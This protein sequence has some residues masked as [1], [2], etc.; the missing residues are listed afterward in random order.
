MTAIPLAAPYP[1]FT[2]PSGAAL[3]GGKIYIG[4]AGLDPRTN[5]ITVYQDA[6]NT[7]TWAQPLRTVSG[8]PSYQGAPSNFYTAANTYSIIVTTNEGRVV[9][10]DLNSSGFVTAGALASRTAGNG[11]SLVGYSPDFTTSL[12][13]VSSKLTDWISILDYAPAGEVLGGNA[14][15]DTAALQDAMTDAAT[16]SRRLVLPAPV[17]GEPYVINAMC[18]VTLADDAQLEIEF[19]GGASIKRA[20]GTIINVDGNQNN[21][22]PLIRITGGA[23]VAFYD[24]NLDGNCNGQTYPTTYSGGF[25]IGSGADPRRH[26]A[27]VQV[28]GRVSGGAVVARPEV[29]FVGG[30]L[31]DAYLNAVATLFVGTVW[32]ERIRSQYNT[33]NCFIGT[34]MRGNVAIDC[35][36]YR[37]GVAQGTYTTLIADLDRGFIQTRDWPVNL[38]GTNQGFP[39]PTLTETL[40]C[41]EWIYWD[42]LTIEE[43][44]IIGVFA[45]NYRQAYVNNIR[46]INHG[47]ARLIGGLY[48]PGL[49]W[50]E[51]GRGGFY[52]NIDLYAGGCRNGVDMPPL[53]LRLAPMD[54][55]LDDTGS[56]YGKEMG[57]YPHYVGTV[58]GWC[59]EDWGADGDP[60]AD[61]NKKN[62]IYNIVTV[63][64]NCYI[65]KVQSE[66]TIDTVVTA[67]NE[68]FYA[69]QQRVHDVF[70]NE[71]NCRN[72]LGATALNFRQL[73]SPTGSP[74]R[75]GWGV[76]NAQDFR[77]VPDA[78]NDDCQIVFFSSG[79]APSA[80][81]AGVTLN[82]VS[83]GVINFT[84]YVSRNIR[85]AIRLHCSNQSRIICRGGNISNVFS[86]IRSESYGSLSVTGYTVDN[87]N[88][89][90]YTDLSSATWFAG[91]A[92]TLLVNNNIGTNIRTAPYQ[93]VMNAAGKGSGAA[94]VTGS[95]S[96]AV[97]TASIAATVLDVTAVTSGSLV[98]GQII[99]GTGVT[100]GT[101]I[102]E[103][104][105]GTTGGIG[106]YSVSVSQTAGSTTVTATGTTLTVTA[107]S[108][109]TLVAGQ[110]ISG[111]NIVPGTMITAFG[112]GTGG[113]GTYTVS[114]SQAAASATITAGNAAGYVLNDLVPGANHWQGSGNFITGSTMTL[115]TSPVNYGRPGDNDRMATPF[116]WVRSGA[117]AP[118]VNAKY[119][120]EIYKNTVGPVYYMAIAVGTGASDWVQ[121]S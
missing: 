7:I 58:S 62:N 119:Q 113:T 95:I 17:N 11:G 68:T 39:V 80:T 83:C 74:S 60:N 25:T 108:S 64:S 70:I 84:G 78:S 24:L 97:V 10:R 37:D 38:S 33:L 109:G 114:V 51:I 104:L 57:Y 91:N 111:T 63:G 47:Y 42:G 56:P 79:W 50:M 107:V 43:A 46:G 4:T 55:R 30:Y 96:G 3:T 88:R 121:V 18:S 2:N 49:V 32:R 12:R 73:G 61:A 13:S 92:G 120:G 22:T 118:S 86:V 112:T 82:Q 19:Q 93:I 99:S 48:E 103:Q 20:D 34:D 31:H 76:I 6:A 9:F 116:D 94:V 41:A 59:G 21:F 40:P 23:R 77:Y 98:A 115:G 75:I 52:D 44:C 5:P 66:G 102:V 110:V 69:V 105:T 26:N 53:V 90:V 101:R 1:F 45:R 117:G 72:H 87:V 67:L 71:I 89:L 106:T 35:Y 81:S 28:F 15:A 8:Y 27:D 16:Y 100:E 54:Y 14:D 65:D 29:Y 85:T 36:S